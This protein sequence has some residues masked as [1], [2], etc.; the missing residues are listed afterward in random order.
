MWYW[1]TGAVVAVGLWTAAPIVIKTISEETGEHI[2]PGDWPIVGW[3]IFAA[4]LVSI[5]LWPTL[6]A[7]L[8]WVPLFLL[9]R[10]SLRKLVRKALKKNQPALDAQED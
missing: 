8:I 6:F 5:P 2:S 1:W 7:L 10:G 9:L 3:L 4:G